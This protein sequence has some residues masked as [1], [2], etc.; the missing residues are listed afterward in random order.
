MNNR[1]TTAVVL[2][3]ALALSVACSSSDSGST[4]SESSGALSVEI[5]QPTD[6]QVFSTQDAGADVDIVAE[7]SGLPSD[8]IRLRVNL[9]DVTQGFLND[10]FAIRLLGVPLGEH[11][12]E[13]AAIDTDGTV[14]SGDSIDTVTITVAAPC[15]EDAECDDG[16]EC[17]VDSCAAGICTY[18]DVPDCGEGAEDP[19]GGGILC[20]N[21]ADCASAFETIPACEIAVCD[22]DSS[23]CVLATAADGEACDDGN[24]C[25]EGD[26]CDAGVCISGTTVDCSDG[27]E[28]T[29][30]L[31]SDADGCLNP[32]A[33]T[34]D[35]GDPCTDDTCDAAA[36]CVFTEK[37]CDDGD[38]CTFDSCNP[39]DGTCINT[40]DPCDDGD[41]CTEGTCDSA[42]GECSYTTTDGPCDDGDPCTTGE[43]CT[44]GACGGGV[45]TACAD[46]G[47][48]CNGE[49][50]CVTAM[51][52]CSS[53]NP[54]V[55][56][57]D[58]VDSDCG[59]TCDDGNNVG[60]DGCSATCQVEGDCEETIDCFDGN[61]CTADACDAGTCSYTSL[62]GDACD[63]GDP[64]TLT[65][66]CVSGEC[67]GSNIDPGCSLEDPV[68]E[69]T[70]SLGE[71][72]S[73]FLK[74]ARES[75]ETPDVSALQFLLTYDEEAV[76]L[77]NFFDE[78]CIPG[79]GCTAVPVAGDGASPL[80]SGHTIALSPGDP[81]DF[82][83]TIAMI[84]VH[85]SAPTTAITDAFVDG[86]GALVGTPEFVE[87]R[88]QLLEDIP[89]A[90][91][92]YMFVSG[93]VLTEASSAELGSYVSDL[94]IFATP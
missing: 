32:P 7:V 50:V 16:N 83:G 62:S 57:D 4:G 39:G 87:A 72:V 5:V 19:E 10:G 69:L 38:V 36:G 89:A 12:I 88:F 64:C 67:V 77:V 6:G 85:F 42:T 56:G 45:A 81:A 18:T 43:V 14:L 51:G 1:P 68:C 90:D 70:G 63:D 41:P 9:N 28:C 22:L 40:A 55:C 46:D 91:P 11:V 66:Q 25:T 80:S 73:C 33:D 86:G 35:D 15:G 82:Q 49:E 44:G 79:F 93:I 94:T 92:V 21:D 60:G 52:G 31:C 74:L 54:P 34:C 13:V 65:D 29:D 3:A 47:D 78:L 27:D 53:V 37:S 23:E 30:D 48:P 75:P 20:K 76:Q 2:F 17:T 71:E 24:S 59:E 84:I 26:A 8:S 61:A 58:N